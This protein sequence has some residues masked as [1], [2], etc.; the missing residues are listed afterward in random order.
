MFEGKWRQA[1]WCL[2]LELAKIKVLV[3]LF[4]FWILEG[5]IHF[6]LLGAVSRIQFPGIVRLQPQ[7]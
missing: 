5:R 2:H 6:V 7:D 4:L 1:T 3:G